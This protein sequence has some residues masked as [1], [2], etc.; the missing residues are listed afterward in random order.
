MATLPPPSPASACRSLHSL[1]LRICVSWGV[2]EMQRS[3]KDSR[4]HGSEQEGRGRRAAEEEKTPLTPNPS[5]PQSRGRGGKT[6]DPLIPNSSGP[7]SRDRG[8]KNR[9][10]SP[11]TGIR[12]GEGV[13]HV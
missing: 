10:A 11:G 2:S 5:G 12:R 8:G 1:R 7:Q 9:T 6:E 13:G 4:T 3:R